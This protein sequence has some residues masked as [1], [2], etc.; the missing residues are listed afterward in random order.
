MSRS[1]GDQSDAAAFSRLSMIR[2]S[3]RPAFT[4][5][6]TCDAA[7][8]APEECAVIEV[9]SRDL[10][11]GVSLASDVTAPDGKVFATAGTAV[12]PMLFERLKNFARML[13]AEENIRSDLEMSLRES[14][15]N[16]GC[17]SFHVNRSLTRNFFT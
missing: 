11:V 1:Q 16:P 12:T 17:R 6:L 5:L 7:R 4:Y 3:L 10:Q 2:P 13:A 14:A 15:K 8:P 9:S